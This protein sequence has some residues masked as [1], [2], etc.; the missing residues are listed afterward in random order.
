MNE[1][2]LS[3]PSESYTQ[4]VRAEIE[5]QL[6]IDI[7]DIRRMGF[8]VSINSE[9]IRVTPI[10]SP[11]PQ[12]ESAAPRDFAVGH[13]SSKRMVSTKNVSAFVTHAIH[14]VRQQESRDSARRALAPWRRY[15]VP[16]TVAV[17]LWEAASGVSVSPRHL[18][19]ILSKAAELEMIRLE[20]AH[21]T[22]ANGFVFSRSYFEE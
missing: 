10:N 14:W 5:R 13:G 20:F 21:R 7:A 16:S 3:L 1:P 18:K 15:F 11:T 12:P 6:R 19:G 8:A 2:E 17:G 22:D 4:L 9:I